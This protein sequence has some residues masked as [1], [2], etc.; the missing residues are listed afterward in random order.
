MIS[1][2]KPYSEYKDSGEPWL[3]K[4]P[5]HW[6]LVRTKS[7][8][9]ERS[10]KGYPDEPMLAATQTKGVVR[11]EQYENRTV[12]ALK[13][14][15]LLKLVRV[16]DFVISLR[17]FQGGIE[18]AREQGIISPAYTI[19]YPKVPQNHAYLAWLFKSKPYIENLTL[20]VTGIRQGQN[21][22]FE[23]LSRSTLPLPSLDEQTAIVRF[24]DYTD[25]RIKRYIHAKQKLIKL[26]NEQKQAIIHQTVTR[27]PDANVRLKHSGVKWLGDVPK[28]WKVLQIRFFAKVGNGSTPS[29]GN[30]GYWAT[31][32]YP[33]LNSS[34]VNQ[35][36]IQNANQ[37]V[38]E[39][40]L[41]ECHLPRIKPGSVLIA[42]TGQGKTRGTS[43]ILGLEATIN[44]HIAFITPK[45]NILS[46]DFLQ[47]ALSG[48]YKYLRSISDDSGST[49]GALTCED[50][51]HFRIAFPP[52]EEQDVLVQTIR[53]QVSETDAT[54]EKIEGDI[55]LLR[56]YNTRLIADVVTGKLDVRINAENLPE[57]TTSEDVNSMGIDSDIELNESEDLIE[58]SVEGNDE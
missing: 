42:I 26:L 38:T 48:A 12:L 22:D 58:S 9:S 23:K 31:S 2:L 36:V 16:G 34:T 4:I 50:L 10:T 1:A 28:H 35:R 6:S 29:R 49:K 45:S 46:S 57:L 39:I 41:K 43:A 55:A 40:A 54:I 20:Y 13:D 37:F 17:S 8:L 11:K 52:R 21:I 44:Q 5:T 15:H 19:L 56:E 53:A 51:K 47:M 3:G 33:W 25:R 24:L 18:Y 27:G 32:G 14:L 30:P 7:L